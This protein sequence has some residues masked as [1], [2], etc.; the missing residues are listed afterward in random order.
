MLAFQQSRADLSIRGEEKWWG[1]RARNP[2]NHEGFPSR[3]R[4]FLVGIDTTGGGGGGGGR[5]RQRSRDQRRASSQSA[6]AQVWRERWQRKRRRGPLRSIREIHL[7]ACRMTMRLCPPLPPTHQPTTVGR[8]D[9]LAA[10]HQGRRSTCH[11]RTLPTLCSSDLPKKK[12]LTSTANSTDCLPKPCRGMDR[13][14]RGIMATVLLCFSRLPMV[15]LWSDRLI[16][17][18][19]SGSGDPSADPRSRSLFIFFS[20][21][22]FFLYR[23]E[24]KVPPV[25][26]PHGRHN[27][28]RGPITLDAGAS[29]CA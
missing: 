21:Y 24:N 15:M 18:E 12:P 7:V 6:S 29:R 11:R 17:L 4:Y 10:M 16:G 3:S 5:K 19:A 26:T 22:L 9:N 2:G 27:A 1:R 13:G 23:A 25:S 14:T 8:T 28:G 20:V